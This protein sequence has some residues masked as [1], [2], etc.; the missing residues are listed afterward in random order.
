MSWPFPAVTSEPAAAKVVAVD[1]DDAFLSYEN[2]LPEPVL[3]GP[4]PSNPV[5]DEP[6]PTKSMILALGKHAVLQVNAVLLL[7]S[8]IFPVVA[9]RFG[10]VFVASAVGSAAPTAPPDANLTR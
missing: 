2:A 4:V 1:V 8:A 7:T 6:K 9:L 3:V 5:A 10:V